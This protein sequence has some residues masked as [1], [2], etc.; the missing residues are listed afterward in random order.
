AKA[1][2][3]AEIVALDWPNVLAVARGHA[4]AAGVADRYR[5][6]AGSALTVAFG[7]GYHLALLVHF[8]QDL[9]PA[10]C[11]RLLATVH[12][13]LALGGRAVAVGFIPNDD[14]ISPP[15]HA[16]FSL[17]MLA[18]TPGGDAY[19]VTDLERMF[20]TAGFA[21]TELRDLTPTSERVMIAYRPQT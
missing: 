6:L 17:S 3:A 15:A 16:A 10:A 2:P 20:R 4:D 19:T 13:A 9:D 1:N 7:T 21:R 18:T 11:E 8:H 14:R 12:A 5:T